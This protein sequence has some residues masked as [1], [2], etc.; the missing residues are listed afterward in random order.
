MKENKIMVVVKEPGKRPEVI[1][2]FE[3]TLEAFQEKVGGYIETVTVATDLCLIV[4]EEGVLKGK[5]FNCEVLG[6]GL[7]GTIIAVGVK[8]DEFASIPG[9]FIPMV[10]RMLEG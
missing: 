1:L 2:S 7:Y 3:N 10:V 8:G 9:K 6:Q 5:P 4:D